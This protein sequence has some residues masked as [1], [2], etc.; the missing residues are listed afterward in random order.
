M[1]Q[2]KLRSFNLRDIVIFLA[3]AEFFHT[4]SHIVL[5]YL[6]SFP[7]QT[8]YVIVTKSLNNNAVIFNGLVTI[9]LLWWA[10]SLRKKH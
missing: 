9:A 3:G 1:K 2:L 7:W 6:V 10:V 4:L 5:A 8:K